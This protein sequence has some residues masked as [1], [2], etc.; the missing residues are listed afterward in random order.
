MSRFLKVAAVA[1]GLAA[2]QFVAAQPTSA[3]KSAIPITG[4][5][6]AATAA[7]VKAWDIDVRPDFAGLPVGS[8]SV[9][10]G[11]EVWDAKCASCHGTFG[12]S[13]EVFAPIVGGTTAEDIAIGRVK[14]LSQGGTRTTL[15]KLSTLSTLW[16]YINRAM[17]WTAPKTLS[18]EEVYAVTAYILH[19]GEIVPADFVLSERNIRE[20]QKRMPNRDGMTDRHGLWR[21]DGAPDV[22]AVACMSNCNT[23]AAKR[24]SELPD[25]ARNSHGNLA[26]QIRPVGAVEGVDTTRPVG[27]APGKAQAPAGPPSAAP[28]P[29]TAASAS[30]VAAPPSG[31]ALAKAHNCLLC[32]GMT[33]QIVG[34]GFNEIATK[35]KERADAQSYLAGKILSGGSGVWGAVPMP[36]QPQLDPAHAKALAAWLAAGAK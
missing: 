5:G 26:D 28:Q 16:D 20:V 13:N 32:H 14:G 1:L 36:A 25:F 10:K 27:S 9:A 6:R 33:S 18:T 23:G 35:Y 7:E 34:P 2:A 8:G 19:L 11:Q 21:A 29:Q 3:P 31:A 24:S 4:L 30:A 17:P 15:A 22:R 12:E